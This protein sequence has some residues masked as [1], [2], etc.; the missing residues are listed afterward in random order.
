[1]KER[2]VV[3]DIGTGTADLMLDLLTQ[4]RAR[5]FVP[6]GL[7]LSFSMLSRAGVKL[8]GNARLLQGSAAAIPLADASC[9]AVMSAFVLRNIK[10][11]MADALREAHRVLKPGGKVYLLEMYVPRNPALALLHGIYLRTILPLIGKL[12]FGGSGSQ[13]YLA[14]TIFGFGTPAEFSKTLGAAGFGEVKIQTLSG[15]IAVL[16]CAAKNL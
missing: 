8:R 2:G 1:M 13:E 14:D 16:H 11:V 3:L 7:D 4:S 9:D 5:G 15:G 6:V 12:V 10:R